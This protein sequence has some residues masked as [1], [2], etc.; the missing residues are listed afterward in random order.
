MNSRLEQSLFR[1]AQRKGEILAGYFF[2][3]LIKHCD[4]DRS[5]IFFNLCFTSL[6]ISQVLIVAQS[7]T[8]IESCPRYGRQVNSLTRLH[9][10]VVVTK[11]HANESICVCPQGTD[12]IPG[13]EVQLAFDY[14]SS[15]SATATQSDTV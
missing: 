6:A 10:T 4:F 15:S 14:R 13:A 8:E 1:N 9:L 11:R 2:A 5:P 3:N 7:R 12:G